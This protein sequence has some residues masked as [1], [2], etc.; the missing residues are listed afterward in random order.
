MTNVKEQATQL[1]N[2]MSEEKVLSALAYLQNLQNEIPS[3]I[4][5]PGDIQ[6]RHAAFN[7]LAGLTADNPVSLEEAREERLSKQ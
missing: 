6:K 2:H 5:S 1:I 4:S 3:S 7:R